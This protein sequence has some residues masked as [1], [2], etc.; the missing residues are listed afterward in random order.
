M[1]HDGDDQAKVTDFERTMAVA[2]QVMAENFEVLR[3]FADLDRTGYCT[4]DGKTYDEAALRTS[5][6]KLKAKL[7]RPKS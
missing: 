4:L 5:G 1:P 6:A 3:T 7:A 2:R